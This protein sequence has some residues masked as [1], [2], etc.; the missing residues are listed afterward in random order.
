MVD[1]EL[2]CGGTWSRGDSSG[3]CDCVHP[4][5]YGKGG[6]DGTL[7]GVF[8]G[9]PGRGGEFEHDEYGVTHGI[10]GWSARNSA[11][12]VRG[13]A[14]TPLACLNWFTRWC[15]AREGRMGH[16]VESLVT[17]LVPAGRL[18]TMSSG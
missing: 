11:V 5:V 14:E 6:E 1:E 9:F 16:S 15:M 10:P 18:R 12:A 2:G 3:V 17:L 4:W 13:P 8:G 7:G